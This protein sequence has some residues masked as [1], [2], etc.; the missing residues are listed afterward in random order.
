[1]TLL[2]RVYIVSFA[3]R[4]TNSTH[5]EKLPYPSTF[6]N[7]VVSYICTVVTLSY[8]AFHTRWSDLLKDILKLAL[9]KVHFFQWILTSAWYHVFKMTEKEFVIFH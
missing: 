1:M 6:F 5:F 7:G 8:S 3:F 4:L 2:T 9:I